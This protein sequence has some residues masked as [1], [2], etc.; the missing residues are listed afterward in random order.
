VCVCVC[1]PLRQVFQTGSQ[2]FFAKYNIAVKLNA[3]QRRSHLLLEVTALRTMLKL[4]LIGDSNVDRYLPIMKAAKEDPAIQETSFMRATNLV[5]LREAL[6]PPSP[7][8]THP[9]VV[10]ACLTNPITNHP[11]DEYK[12]LVVHCNQTFA[13]ILAWIQEGQG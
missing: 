9:N 5:Q 2:S 7:T 3:F 1:L 6:V 8:E 13:Q 4:H 12:T 11:F 10:L